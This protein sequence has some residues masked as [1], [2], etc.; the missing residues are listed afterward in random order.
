MGA[1]FG[2]VAVRVFKPNIFVILDQIDMIGLEALQRFIDAVLNPSEPNEWKKYIVPEA[3]AKPVSDYRS[4]LFKL[5]GQEAKAPESIQWPYIV[6]V[7]TSTLD[8]K[9]EGSG[10]TYSILASQ[11]VIAHVVKRGN[12]FLVVDLVP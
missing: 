6:D 9:V 7:L 2:E 12:E 3:A 8:F 4:C 1:A 11:K 10:E 5:S